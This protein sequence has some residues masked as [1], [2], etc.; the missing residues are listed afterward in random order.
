MPHHESAPPLP[1]ATPEARLRAQKRSS[2]MAMP[3]QTPILKSPPKG[4]NAPP[5]RAAAWTPPPLFQAYGQ[6][7]KHATLDASTL[8]AEAILRGETSGKNKLDLTIEEEHDEFDGPPRI[9]HKRTASSPG[10]AGGWTQKIFMLMPTGYVLQYAGEGQFDRLPEK[11]LQLDEHSV[12]FATDVLPGKHWVLQISHLEEGQQT[13]DLG[14]AR[15]RFSRLSFR[16]ASSRRMV[17][18]LLLVM[19]SPEDMDA[20]MSLIR[21]EIEIVGGKAHVDLSKAAKRNGGT[22]APGTT[23]EPQLV[24]QR[25]SMMPNSGRLGQGKALDSAHRPSSRDHAGGRDH[26]SAL[27]SSPVAASSE[28]MHSTS[29]PQRPSVGAASLGTASIATTAMSEDQAQLEKLR[30]DARLSFM[31]FGTLNTSRAT[32]P[33]S[34]PTDPDEQ[35]LPQ[36]LSPKRRTSVKVTVGRRSASALAHR[37]ESQLLS[38]DVISQSKLLRPRSTYGPPQSMSV[39]RSGNSRSTSAQRESTTLGSLEPIPIRSASPTADKEA[40]ASEQ[41]SSSKPISRRHRHSTSSSLMRH[42]NRS[43]T[44][45]AA[46]TPSTSAS[47]EEGDS[48]LLASGEF[49]FPRVPDAASE[50]PSLTRN[51]A[52]KDFA[53]PAS[54]PTPVPAVVATDNVESPEAAATS[55]FH[56]RDSSPEPSSSGTPGEG[57]QGRKRSSKS[58]PSFS[59]TPMSEAPALPSPEKGEEAPATMEQED[60]S[61]DEDSDHS[62]EGASRPGTSLAQRASDHGAH[63]R[64]SSSADSTHHPPRTSSY[65]PTQ[66]TLGTKSAKTKA[67]P[68]AARIRNRKSLTSL[69]P[70]NPMGP[71]SA[72]PPNMPLPTVPGIGKMGAVSSAPKAP[73]PKLPGSVRRGQKGQRFPVSPTIPS[74]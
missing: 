18:N 27:A 63:S 47:A 53:R 26:F 74:P 48:P 21:K 50:G 45:A 55:F 58:T 36:G 19:R 16:S 11:L 2:K 43:I 9:R 40:S 56:T 66:R 69:L 39:P 37:R 52:T 12:A 13:V 60:D 59:T 67:K 70:I 65:F 72:P 20:W 23:G 7:I 17:S 4:K 61:S 34:S 32:S 5:G 46:D 42:G 44:A 10:V 15:S 25:Y 14:G 62:L 64:S 38:G 54:S 57:P 3:G 35:A 28:S 1:S 8:S 41:S 30:D 31:S 29:S 49:A 68:R 33:T 6:A 51:I 71:P 73:S 22:V 24:M